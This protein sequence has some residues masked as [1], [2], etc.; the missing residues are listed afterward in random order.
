MLI[1]VPSDAQVAKRIEADFGEQFGQEAIV[2]ISPAAN[3]DPQVL[4][5][6]DEALDNNRQIIPVLLQAVPLP[7][8]IE[9]L[10]AVDFTK[11]YNADFLRQRFGENAEVFHMKVH[12]PHVRSSNRRSAAVFGLL[13]LVMFLG[14]LYLVGVLGV[15][16]PAE[17][18]DMVET[19]IILTRNYYVDQVLP[20]STE[21]AANF[22]ATVDGA[23]STLRPILIA[24]ATA[25]AGQ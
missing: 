11:G 20:R 16:A 6:L 4:S 24:T 22:Q 23:R 1:Y 9:H 14:G 21:D 17:E 10:E 5:A 2:L 8:S 19:E 18:Y 25:L 13:A 15:M 7:K 12:T 3:K